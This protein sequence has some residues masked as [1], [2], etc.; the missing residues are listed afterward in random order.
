MSVYISVELQKKIRHRFADC[1]AYCR[2]AESLT[3]TTF[4]V[5]HII[6]RS[7]G[8]ET[9]FENLCLACPSCNRY[10]ATRQTA[11]DPNT[12]EE[13]KLFHP[14]QQTWIEH[15]SWNEDA[16]EIVGLTAVGRSTIHALKMNRPQ[17]T[18][19]RKM[20]VKLGEHPPNI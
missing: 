4:E 16:T 14:Q 10:K 15:F 19:V 17:L 6:P 18:R 13:V 2:T 20:W 5:E 9:V 7:A 3:V 12:Q 8:G 11:V 1:C